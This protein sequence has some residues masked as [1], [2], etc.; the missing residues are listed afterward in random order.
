MNDNELLTAVREQRN[1][2]PMTVP[3]EQV[4]SRGRR[5]RARRRVPA[6]AAA[7][8]VT[9][10]AVI[11]VT[12]LIAGPQAG[13]GPAAAHSLRARLLTAIDAARGDILS[14]QGRPTGRGQH[15]G[16]DQTLTY[17][18]YP[19]PGQQVRI[20]TL[21]LGADGKLFR[22]DESI[23]TMPAG[24]GTP[25]MNPV[26]GEADLT[27]TG[28]YI[29]VYPPRHA[30]GKWQ[31]LTL[32]LGL[33]ADAAGLRH[34]LATGQFTIIRRGVADGHKAI[35]L[36]MTGLNPSKTGLHATA[37]R[38]WVDAASYL[39]LRQVLQFSTGRQ[40]VT[41]YRFFP[42][43]AANQA[44][45]RTVIPAGYHRTTLLPGQGRSK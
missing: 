29:G 20:H 19:R 30:W 25:A 8:A 16:S 12:S 34:Q 32:T 21:G 26:D 24:H 44:K 35:E 11:A 31:H 3:V 4:I 5:V 27:V 7:L 13:G 1:K 14:A 43:T 15:G 28:T 6:L 41:D 22:D 40:Y 9:A 23:F 39:P 10:A 45:L 37:A 38:L 36:G 18:W 17:P 33:P 42:P 2:I